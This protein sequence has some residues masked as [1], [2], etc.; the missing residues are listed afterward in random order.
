MRAKMSFHIRE[1]GMR[2]SRGFT[3]VELMIALLIGLI[4]TIGIVSLFS[5]TSKT[6][7]FQEALARLQE[8]GRYATLRIESDLR[9]SAAQYCSAYKGTLLTG[10]VTPMATE[11]PPAVYAANLFLPDS[12]N[13]RS[14]DAAGYAST[15]NATSGYGLSQRFF[16][17]GYT[18][19][20]GT[21]CTPAL[22][23]PAMFPPAGLSAGNRVPNSDI[24]TTRYQR[25]TGWPVVGPE[26]DCV[27]G[28][29]IEISPQPGDDLVN[30]SPTP[31]ELAYL[32]DCNS[33]AI[34]PIT[35]R[36]GNTLTL[37]TLLGGP[38]PPNC[39][40]A[41]GRDKRLFNF[42][43]DFVTITYYLA[44]RADD[45]PDARPNSGADRLVPVLI[46]RVNGV[47][48]ELVRGIDRLDF[49]YG[50]RDNQGA[51]RFLNAEQVNNNLGGT[52][53]CTPSPANVPPQ[54][55][56]NAPGVPEPQC[57]WRSVQRVEA[58]LL[59]GPGQEVPSMDSISRGYRYL[60]VEYNP[61]ENTPLPSGILSMNVPRREFIAHA[62]NRNRVL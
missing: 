56:E 23:N 40:G 62:A 42:S 55:A 52:I 35:G 4:G 27:S 28:G 58:H 14:V 3:L 8:N 11:R 61:D 53:T 44:F 5:G 29:T 38:Y 9:M 48:Q 60:D 33:P 20:T 26:A 34:I 2:H 36:S 41:S 59:V 16:M 51:L 31:L 24:L 46:R 25:G 21:S 7:R 37:G 45:N 10:T 43:T 19:T 18:C 1:T 15:S 32:S 12:G 30:F 22:P 54:T 57:L 49:R 39:G 47:E 13:M 6:N 50:V 17:Q